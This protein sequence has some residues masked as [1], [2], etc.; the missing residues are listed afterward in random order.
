MAYRVRFGNVTAELTRA[1]LERAPE[2]LMSCVLLPVDP[3]P[4]VHTIPSTEQ[5]EAGASVAGWRGGSEDLFKV[6]R[7]VST[8]HFVSQK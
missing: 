5:E 7:V 1:D 8:L 3:G 2:S 6:W 4:G